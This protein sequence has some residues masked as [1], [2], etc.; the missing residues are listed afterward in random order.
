MTYYFAILTNRW[1]IDFEL[2]SLNLALEQVCHSFF[3]VLAHAARRVKIWAIFRQAVVVKDWIKEL[4]EDLN[5]TASQ[6]DFNFKHVQ[7]KVVLEENIK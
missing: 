7:N 3:R 1:P 5:L 6:V 2:W 4:I